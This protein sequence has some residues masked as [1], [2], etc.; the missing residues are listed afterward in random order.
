[1]KKAAKLLLSIILF[2]SVSGCS[3]S[4]KSSTEVN[5]TPIE[6]EQED[7]PYETIE[8]KSIDSFYGGYETYK[9]EE[10]VD[11]KIGYPTFNEATTRYNEF[12]ADLLKKA[13]SKNE[14]EI[15]SPLS[16]YY[17][18]G[19]LSNGA[20]GDTKKEIESLMKMTTED[21]NY[22]LY[23]L[24]H[25]FINTQW[26]KI[27]N[28]SNAL[29]FNNAIGLSLKPD[30]VN[31]I[32]T[33][34]GNSIFERDF[35]DPISITNEV[36]Q[37]A[38]NETEGAINNILNETDV[39]QDTPFLILNA[40]A[41]GARW[42]IPFDPSNNEIQ[43]FTNYDNSIT[44]IE[45]MKI[46]MDGYWCDEQSEGFIRYLDNGASFYAI[47]PNEG[48]DIYDYIENMDGNTFKNY[49]RD[50]VMYVDCPETPGS[51]DLHITN[52]TFP[53]FTYDKEYSI[54]DSLK[55]LGLSNIFDYHTADF[56]NMTEGENTEL[57]YVNDIKQKDTIY[58]DEYE[59]KAAAVTAVM[60]G[61]GAAGD[62]HEFIYHDVV[63]NRPFIYAIIDYDC[64]LFVGVVSNMNTIE[65]PVGPSQLKLKANINI[66]M[67]HSTDGYKIDTASE[68]TVFTYHDTYFDGTYTWYEIDY[69]GMTAY[70]ADQNGEWIEL[71]K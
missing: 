42:T 22:F 41:S 61:L 46:S 21:I 5:E 10:I 65:T 33:Y 63:F 40:L 70:V 1:M 29:W 71:I 56:S 18:M 23:D 54:T 68:G 58:V 12:S 2:I 16:L 4:N 39:E 35:N 53:K 25:Q 11:Y 24:N 34:Y 48:I 30:Y 69:Q 31:T 6:T 32:Q 37:W 51:M 19:I 49:R 38:S 8:I 20:N 52:L 13:S 59:V 15:I 62:I 7:T 64:P 36:N 43:P 27:F 17:A 67:D 55:A 60:G 44:D 50:S 66:R 45:M 9:D 3:N 26:G 57:L 14:N 28:S 47:L